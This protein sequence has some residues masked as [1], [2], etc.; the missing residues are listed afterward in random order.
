MNAAQFFDHW[1]VVWS[2]LMR[3]VAMLSDQHLT[4]RP[5]EH[6]SRSVAGILQHITDLEEGW[7][8]FV[9]RRARPGWPDE[10]R[11][12]PST[13]TA[14]RQDMERI[15]KETMTY[16]ETLAVEDFNRIVQVPRDGTPKLSWILWH[17]FEQEIHHRGELFLCLSLLGMERPIVDRPS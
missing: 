17:V 8:H 5:S 13:V 1:H 2:D 11:Q 10:R 14:L 15:H 16:L 12:P 6:Y 4:F 7:I 3:G 9:V